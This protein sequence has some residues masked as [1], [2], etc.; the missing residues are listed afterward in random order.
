MATTIVVAGKATL[1]SLLNFREARGTRDR[2]AMVMTLVTSRRLISMPSCAC[3]GRFVHSLQVHRRGVSYLS[4][5]WMLKGP[6]PTNRRG[7]EPSE[8]VLLWAEAL[9]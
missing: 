9:Q 5:L 7:L 8:H 3:F 6:Q 2:P 1:S 4:G